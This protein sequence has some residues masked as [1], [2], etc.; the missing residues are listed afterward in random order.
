MI[1]T[2]DTAGRL[3]SHDYFRNK[4]EEHRRLADEETAPEQR[5]QHL[6]LAQM[7]RALADQTAGRPSVRIGGATAPRIAIPKGIFFRD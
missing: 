2:S 4:A 1:D 6:R 5:A 7:Y 3:A